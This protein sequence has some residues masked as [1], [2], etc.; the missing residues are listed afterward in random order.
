MLHKFVSD[1][2]GENQKISMEEWLL[3]ADW[4]NNDQENSHVETKIF[5]LCVVYICYYTN[6]FIYCNWF[7]RVFDGLL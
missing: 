1:E 6:D 4:E 5:N 2:N 7:F 3:L